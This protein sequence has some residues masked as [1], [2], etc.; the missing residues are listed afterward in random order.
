MSDF[1]NMTEPVIGMTGE[2]DAMWY[3][4]SNLDSLGI[5]MAYATSEEEHF[6]ESF[7]DEEGLSVFR[8]EETKLVWNL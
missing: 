6:V 3:I 5:A 2:S 1:L 7:M 4:T 8:P